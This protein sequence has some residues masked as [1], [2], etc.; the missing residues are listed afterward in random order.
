M[1]T[2]LT[3]LW[4]ICDPSTHAACT[5]SGVMEVTN[6]RPALEAALVIEFHPARSILEGDGPTFH[7]PVETLMSWPHVISAK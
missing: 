2:S 3:T 6:S 5:K 7:M 1:E 4:H